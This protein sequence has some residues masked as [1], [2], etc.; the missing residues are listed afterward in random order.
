MSAA[1]S[2]AFADGDEITPDNQ[3]QDSP[4]DVKDD[5]IWSSLDEAVNYTYSQVDTDEAGGIAI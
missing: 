2:S 3:G 4:N 1:G 5:D